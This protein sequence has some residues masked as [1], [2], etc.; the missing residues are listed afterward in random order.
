MKTRFSPAV[1][2]ASVAA[3]FSLFATTLPVYAQAPATGPVFSLKR[4][5]QLPDEIQMHGSAVVGD[6]IYVF[7]GGTMKIGW[8]N[9]VF[10]AAIYR[11]GDLSPWRNETPMLERRYY[12]ENSV[13]VVNN[14]IYVVGGATAADSKTPHEQSVPARDALWTSVKPDGTLTEWR[15]S[16][17]FPDQARA[18]AATCSSDRNLYILGG[19]AGTAISNS[20]LMA[21]FDAQ[22]AP[23]NWRPVAT[24]PRPLWFHGAAVIDDRMYVWGGMF[25]PQNNVLNDKVYSAKV[26]SDGTLGAWETEP[27]PMTV[28][29]YSS[30][31]CGFNDYLIAVSGRFA[32]GVMTNNISFTR[33]VN[34]HPQQWVMLQTDLESRV[35]QSA[36]LDRVRGIVFVTGG[37][38]KAT[39]ADAGKVLPAVQAFQIPQPAE[40]RLVV[41]QAT[42]AG[43]TVYGGVGTPVATATAMAGTAAGLPRLAIALEQAKSTRSNVVAFFYSP[44]V[45]ASKRV[46]DNMISQA[47]FRQTLGNRILAGVDVSG[48]DSQFCYKYGVFRVPSV[49]EIGADGAAKLTSRRLDTPE[50]QQELLAQ[51]GQGGR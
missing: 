36:A 19:K 40:S 33:L 45:P 5:T 15:H 6:R 14:R 41:Q 46:W 16:A 43:A 1:F 2:F 30:A 50:T 35:Y 10:S 11:N 44:E 31:F 24:L 42:P 4:P 3:V 7:G 38:F 23:I 49:V 47:R 29:M 27:I 8:S 25:Q 28:P 9:A 12:I 32:N 18:N 13:A 26:N 48:A 22:G 17:Q 37:R 34:K 21:D 39:S 20:V 51:L